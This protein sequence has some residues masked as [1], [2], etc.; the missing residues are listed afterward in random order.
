MN[1]GLAKCTR[2][3][4]HAQICLWKV[5]HL[6]AEIVILY[7]KPFCKFINNYQQRI[8]SKSGENKQYPLYLIKGIRNSENVI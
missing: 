7:F 6:S 1:Y 2:E 8:K 3:F 4:N 5:Y